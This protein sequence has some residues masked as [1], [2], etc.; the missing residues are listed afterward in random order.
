MQAEHR[1]TRL[2]NALSDAI[3]HIEAAGLP[4]KGFKETL[5]RE[6]S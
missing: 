5:R 1:I 6:S 2:L 3:G 4:A